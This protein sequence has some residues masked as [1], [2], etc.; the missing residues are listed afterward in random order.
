MVE[1]CLESD[2]SYIMCGVRPETFMACSMGQYECDNGSCIL[3]SQLC[4]GHQDCK[5][6]QD[7]ERC[8]CVHN[9]I[10]VFV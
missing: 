7:E 8:W 1:N 6:G 3:D 2:V 4:D 5:D 10:Q 9:G